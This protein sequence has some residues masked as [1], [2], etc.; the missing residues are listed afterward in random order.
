MGSDISVNKPWSIESP[1]TLGSQDMCAFSGKIGPEIMIMYANNFLSRAWSNWH[2]KGPANLSRGPTLTWI[3]CLE[4][5]L[6]DSP[7]RASDLTRLKPPSGSEILPC[8]GRRVGPCRTCRGE[9]CTGCVCVLRSH[10][11]LAICL[12][13]KYLL[14]FSWLKSSYSK[15]DWVLGIQKYL[16]LI[17]FSVITLRNKETEGVELF[18]PAESCC[19]K[20]S[21]NLLA[22][23]TWF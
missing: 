23:G 2:L 19:I 13:P 10:L 12:C 22:N 17:L 18:C 1:L 14:T 11:N 8:R 7:S 9:T 3:M 20:K 16:I 21:P 5:R 4:G 6:G 15:L